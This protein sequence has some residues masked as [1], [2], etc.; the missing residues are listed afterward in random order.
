M[1]IQLINGQPVTYELTQLR[2]DYPNTS[3]PWPVPADILA[4]YAIYEVVPDPL[5]VIDEL[6]QTVVSDPVV[7][8]NG[9]WRQP[10]HVE[11][12]SE[13]QASQRVRNHRNELLAET[14][15]VTLRSVDTGVPVSSNYVTYRTALRNLPEQVGFPYSVVW[16]TKPVS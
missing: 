2:L 8:D 1:Y 15:W 7:F 10:Y 9:V 11:N 12:I 13:M 6:T 14:D 5:P 4:E 16:P 3:F